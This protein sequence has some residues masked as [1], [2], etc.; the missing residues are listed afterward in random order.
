[1]KYCTNCGNELADDAKFCVNCGTKVTG[2][3][4]TVEPAQSEQPVRQEAP[5]TPEPTQTQANNQ[6]PKQENESVK[7]AQDL[8]NGYLSY[9]LLTL[10]KP[11]QALGLEPSGYGYIQI[12]VLSI[13][14]TFA[15][16]GVLSGFFDF[17]GGGIQQFSQPFGY[18]PNTPSF[19][20]DFGIFTRLFIGFLLFYGLLFFLTYIIMNVCSNDLLNMRQT[21]SRYGGF[22]SLNIVLFAVAALFGFIGGGFLLFLATLLF[23][24]GLSLLSF[25][26]NYSLYKITTQPRINILYILLIGNV[27]MAIVLFIVA[28]IFTFSLM[29]EFIQMLDSLYLF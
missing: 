25:A 24:L 21:F 17:V 5:V 9:F 2:E 7:A 28:A 14:S 22:L 4:Q 1:M 27:I 3:E 6:Q 26:F 8:A 19:D 16:S 18:T 29:S 23:F 10:K 15:L 13:I 11:S 20:L 12:I